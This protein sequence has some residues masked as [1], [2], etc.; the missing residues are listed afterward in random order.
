MKRLL[1]FFLLLSGTVYGQ[2]GYVNMRETFGGGFKYMQLREQDIPDLSNIYQPL[3]LNLT[4][5][6]GITEEGILVYTSGGLTS[7]TLPAAGSDFYTIVRFAN[8]WVERPLIP[9]PATTT[10]DLIYWDDDTDLFNR[11]GVGTSTQFLGSD[12]T[13]PTYKN[14]SALSVVNNTKV[15]L[16]VSGNGSTALL[17]SATITISKN[18]TPWLISEGGTNA[19]SL[20][21]NALLF[22]NGSSFA[23]AGTTSVLS[24][25][26][27]DNT[28][29]IL[30]HRRQASVTNTAMT[31]NRFT[32][33]STGTMANGFAGQL[34]FYHRDADN[35]DNLV[36]TMGFSRSNGADNTADFV[37]NPSSA[38]S[39]TER[40]RV[41]FDGATTV[42][43]LSGTGN[44]LVQA[45]STGLL[46]ASLTIASATYT[47]TLTAVTNIDAG[48]SSAF[49]TGYTRIGN[50]VTVFGQLTIDATAAASTATEL[51]VSL[52]VASN[53]AADQDLGGTAASDVLA[54]AVIRIKA[55]ATNDRASFVFKS[56][57]TTADSYNF[58]F[59]YQVK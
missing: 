32:A 17:N 51:G 15:D 7:S 40:L 25:L 38:G 18:A 43:G 37:V 48:T 12:G 41:A 36:G 49:V 6:A 35:A 29:S 23:T 1:F 31:V 45:S 26:W 19:T 28:N 47:P 10:G 30:D 11:V 44:R 9:N 27:W 59:S 20:V 54:G 21:G 8:E 13:R 52:P 55:D 56:S 34:S 33:I 53:L 4:A 42:S 58:Q 3:N 50:N 22:V 5:I 57:T 46:S 16:A 2:A 14:G 24:G 39:A